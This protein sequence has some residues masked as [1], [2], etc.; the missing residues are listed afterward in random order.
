ML[1]RPGVTAAHRIGCGARGEVHGR[2]RWGGCECLLQNAL[3]RPSARE[4]PLDRESRLSLDHLTDNEEEARGECVVPPERPL[5]PVMG[6]LEDDGFAG[7]DC[8]VVSRGRVPRKAHLSETAAFSHL[9]E[10]GPLLCVQPDL[11]RADEEE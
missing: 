1:M 3:L 5:Q 11:P 10:D 7:S 9:S 4:Y 2:R 6:D 8:R